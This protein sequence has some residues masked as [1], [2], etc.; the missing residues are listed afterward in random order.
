[1]DFIASFI[2]L[3]HYCEKEGYKGWDPYDGLNSQVF[4][5]LPGL[6]H[7]ALCRLVMIQAFKRSP[8]NLRRLAMVPKQYNAKG[9]G[10]FLQGYCNIYEAVQASPELASQFGSLDT[11]EGHIGSLAALLLKLRSAGNYHGSCWGYNFDWQSRREFLFPKY[12]PTVVATKFCATALLSAYKINGDERLL[13]AVLS[14]AEFVKHDLH[15]TPQGSGFLFSYSPL[16]GHDTVVNASLLGSELLSIAYK[17]TG[18]EACRLAA[19]DS[20]RACCELQ[21]PDG[22]W[23]YG[24]QPFQ[25]W[26]DSFHTGYDLEALQAYSDN[27]GDDSCR[28][29]IDKGLDFYTSRFFLAGGMPRY[30]HNRTFPIDIHCPAQLMVTLSLLHRFQ[31]WQDLATQ[32]MDWTIAHM[33]DKKGYF[34]YQ[35]KKFGSSRISYMRWSNAFMFYAMS[36]YLKEVYAKGQH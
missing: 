25:H 19:S 22:S 34:Y 14:T 11:L 20:V 3:K 29:S 6:K 35:L 15:R 24:C 26:V 18:D 12:T 9:V 36:F 7:S 5:A 21:R 23:P 27:T 30:Y 17:Y 16:S 10:L 33:Q 31:H 28:S 1:M 32:V 4:Q 13:R 8:L 2:K